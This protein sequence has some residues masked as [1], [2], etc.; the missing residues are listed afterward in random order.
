M[1]W[2]GAQGF[3]TPIEDETFIL[4]DMG[5]YG[6]THTERNLTCAAASLVYGSSAYDRP[7]HLR[8]GVLLQRTYDPT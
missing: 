8:C 7:F 5:V 2:G 6:N 3:Q 1:T 4:K